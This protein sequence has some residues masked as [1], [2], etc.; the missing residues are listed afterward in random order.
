MKG[1]NQCAE[2]SVYDNKQLYIFN[3]PVCLV[4]ISRT[5]RTGEIN[6]QTRQR[7]SLWKR[8]ISINWITSTQRNMWRLRYS[9]QRICQTT[10]TSTSGEIAS[11]STIRLVIALRYVQNIIIAATAN[12][13]THRQFDPNPIFCRAAS[14]QRRETSRQALWKPVRL[15]RTSS[16]VCKQQKLPR[17]QPMKLSKKCM[18]R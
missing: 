10:S 17:W 18:G 16:T 1:K 2:R 3:P 9:M 7:N 15:T 12:N 8:N 14:S 13:A 11:R 5:S 6:W 4:M